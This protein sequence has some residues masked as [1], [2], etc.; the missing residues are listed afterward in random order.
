MIRVQQ[1]V[2]LADLACFIYAA[3]ADIDNSDPIIPA[4][5]HQ[6]ITLHL[7]NRIGIS[8]NINRPN[9]CKIAHTI[10]R[11]PTDPPYTD[12][13]IKITTNNQLLSISISNLGQDSYLLSGV[14]RFYQL[15]FPV[16]VDVYTAVEAT[17]HDMFVIG[18]I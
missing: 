6:L 4:G 2:V 10:E 14:Y 15:F 7:H 13:R 3:T 8:P 12:L 9:K 17:T 11:I 16:V 5:N 1:L 18:Q